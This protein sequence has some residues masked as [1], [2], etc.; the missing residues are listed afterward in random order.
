VSPEEEPPLD[1]TLHQDLEDLR[2]AVAELRRAIVQELGELAHRILT[3]T[4]RW[5][6]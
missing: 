6:W 4:G 5:T 2:A 1:G 3:W